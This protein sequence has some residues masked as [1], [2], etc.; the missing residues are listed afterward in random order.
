M[1]EANEEVILYGWLWCGHCH[2]AAKLLQGMKVP[3]FPK[4]MEDKKIAGEVL[5]KTGKLAGPTIVLPNGAILINPGP[6]RLCQEIQELG[7]GVCQSA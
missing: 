2:E 6:E 1:A 3:Y 7:L 5:R 4:M